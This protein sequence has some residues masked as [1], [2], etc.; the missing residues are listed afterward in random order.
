MIIFKCFDCYHRFSMQPNAI[1]NGRGCPFCA[2]PSNALCN[3]LECVRCYEK[4]IISHERQV[5]W[6]S[7]NTLN[8][9]YLFRNATDLVWYNC[10][11]GHL[12]E[13]MVCA[14]NRGTMV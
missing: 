12:F 5:A 9:R 4:T 2:E 14:V 3:N 7:I 8:P 1:S 6:A 11:K 13:I 10:E